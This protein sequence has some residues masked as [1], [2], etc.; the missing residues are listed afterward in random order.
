MGLDVP[1]D[2]LD[3]TDFA[4]TQEKS[5]GWKARAEGVGREGYA[6]A[7]VP[8]SNGGRGLETLSPSVLRDQPQAFGP[9]D[10]ELLS[11]LPGPSLA[12]LAKKDNP[13]LGSRE[14]SLENGRRYEGAWDD[15]IGPKRVS[16][17]SGSRSPRLTN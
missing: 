5:P 9:A 6:W 16:G 3:Y 4:R 11:G 13:R 7:Q 17:T 12:S 1:R 8:S 15:G 10:G 2:S 14:K